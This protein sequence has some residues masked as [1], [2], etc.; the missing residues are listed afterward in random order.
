MIGIKELEENVIGLKNSLEYM[1][2]GSHGH[3]G[4][5][6]T[7]N[8]GHNRTDNN[9]YGGTVTI[10]MLAVNYDNDLAKRVQT[11][12]TDILEKQLTDAQEE[13]RKHISY[14]LD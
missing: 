2:E 4:G 14:L 1:K 7:M 10:S 6:F 13:L 11:L 8:S 5:T 12:A 9:V 3:P